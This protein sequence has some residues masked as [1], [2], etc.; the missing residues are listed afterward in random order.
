M[1]DLKQKPYYLDKTQIK[2]VEDTIADMTLEEKIGQLFVLLKAV[3]GVDEEKIIEGLKKSHQGGLRWQGGNKEVVYLQNMTYQRN[4]KVPLF[5]AANCDDGG[6]GCLPEGTYVATAAQAGASGNPEIAYHIGLTAGREASSIGCNWMFN[7]ISDI[8][9]NWRNTIVNTRSF[10]NQADIV[11][12]NAK[13][14][15]QGV[16]DANAN[17]AC[18][19]KH[20][21]GDGVEELD[22]HLA[23]GI[24]TLSGDQWEN[25]FG[26]VYQSLI[27]DGIEAI[28]VGHIAQP[29]L[30]RKL[31]P[32]IKDEEIMPATLSPELLQDLLREQMKFNGIIITDASHMIGFSAMK[33][34]EDA[35]PKAIAAG[36]DMFLFANDIDEDIAY[37]K[38]GIEKG[39][40]SEE[41]LSDALHRILGLKA[42]L[43]L[44]DDA[45][46]YP[47]SNLKN[48]VVGC[49]EHR[50]YTKKA[51]YESITLVKDTQH[52]LPI[53]PEKR[54][55]ALLV[56]VQSTPTSKGYQ[57]DPAKQIVIDELQKAGFR[58]EVCPNYHDLEVENGVSP[59]NFVKM[60]TH[61]TRESFIENND[62]VFL[63]FNIKGYA[64]ENNVRIRWSCNHSCE[65]PWYINEVPTIGISLNYTNH[66]IDVPQIKTFINAY[67]P[68]REN[69]HEAISKIC[70]K[71]YFM[72][73]A[74]ETV[75]CGRW[76]THL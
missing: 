38:A 50:D 8:Y 32:G 36:C 11:I 35:V 9:M 26:K 51:A 58:V 31:R 23:L 74:N 2:W 13:A 64:Q 57:G 30:S 48:Q 14:Y 16:K 45:V 49:K 42:K 6:D 7:P 68:H 22:Q 43:H 70:G 15:I 60:L 44:Y 5:I 1:V 63:V 59:M 69:I 29:E 73:E 46:R 41:R 53:N 55:K 20:F 65:L 56:Y 17:M 52:I 24:N 47:D 39:I 18:T 19:A 54:K 21:P 34:R 72:G 27:D 71:S 75:F 4:S 61:E 25:T 40:I 3:P 66:L 10:G 62:I 37:M 67:G 76:E 33:K 28:M 12:K